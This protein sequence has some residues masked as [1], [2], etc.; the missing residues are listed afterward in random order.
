MA[1]EG[2]PLPHAKNLREVDPRAGKNVECR[3][4]AGAPL[5][6]QL[7]H[8][9]SVAG[10]GDRTGGNATL[11]TVKVSFTGLQYGDLTGNAAFLVFITAYHHHI[12]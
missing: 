5:T 6:S 7:S 8:Q 2:I 10:A 9:A 1:C 3:R 12:F 4:R 11:H